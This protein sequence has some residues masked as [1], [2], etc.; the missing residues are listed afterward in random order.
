MTLLQLE[1]ETAR[2]ADNTPEDVRMDWAA[3]LASLAKLEAGLHKVDAELGRLHADLEAFGRS[4]AE[5]CA[6]QYPD[7]LEGGR[8]R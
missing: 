2:T 4:N 7:Q 1:R 3:I 5:G 8:H 6:E